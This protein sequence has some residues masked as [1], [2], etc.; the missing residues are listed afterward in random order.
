MTKKG[1]LALI[2]SVFLL[3]SACASA[4]SPE[5]MLAADVDNFA[6]GSPGFEEEAVFEEGAESNSGGFSGSQAAVERIVIRNADMTVVVLDPATSSDTIAAMAEDFGGFVV[7]A[8]VYQASAGESI[9]TTQ[10][11]IT[12]RVPSER[13]EEALERIASDAVEVRNES[14]SGEDVTQQYTDLGSRLTNL[15]AAEVQLREIMASAFE[16]DDVLRVFDDLTRVREEIELIKGQRQYFE[17]AA[18]LSRISVQLIPDALAQPLQF[19]GWQPEGTAKSAVEAL[20]TAL[21]FIAD[22][23]IWGLICIIPVGLILGLPGFFVGRAFLRRRRAKKMR[24]AAEAGLAVETEQ[25]GS[26]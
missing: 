13:L 2:M 4:A 20:V 17:E 22:A 19:G 18:R 24:R 21:Q 15:E 16:T 1:L 14:V 12:I 7:S 23:A 25:S 3:L 11:S 10:A 8:N 9:T 6:S 26:E 5:A